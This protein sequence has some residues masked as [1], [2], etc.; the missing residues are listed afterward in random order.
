MTE[1]KLPDG[2]LDETCR[3]ASKQVKITEAVLHPCVSEEL[4]D[5]IIALIAVK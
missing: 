1:V 4:L 3:L 2:W 5:Q